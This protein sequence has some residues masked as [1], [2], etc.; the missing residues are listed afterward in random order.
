MGVSTGF[1]VYVYRTNQNRYGELEKAITAMQAQQVDQRIVTTIQSTPEAQAARDRII[2]SKGEIWRPVQEQIKD[3]VVQVFSQN[4]EIDIEQPFKTPNQYKTT[5][6]GFFINDQG[7]LLTNAHVVASAKAVWIQI[8]SFGK[9]IFDTTVVGFA[10]D[11]DIALL[12][13][14]PEGF[15]SIKAELKKVPHLTLGDSDRV[16]R[17]DEVMALGYPLGQESLKSTTGVISGRESNLIQMS[18]PIN[19]GS[20]GGPLLDLNGMVV[21]IN[22][23]GILEAQNI[24]YIIPINEVKVVLPNL[25]KEKILRKPF[26]GILYNNGTEALTEYLGNPKPGGCYIVEVVK[27]STL[28][29]AGVFRG[30]MIYE[31]NGHRIDMYGDMNVPW[32]EDKISITDYAARLSI[33]DT[34]KMVIYRNG[35]RKELTAPFSQMALPSIRKVYP[36]YEEIAYETVAGMVVME[37]TINHIAAMANKVPGLAQ[38]AELKNQAD[39][40]LIISHVFPTSYMARTR[41]ISKGTTINQVNGQSVHGLDEFRKALKKSLTTGF[42]T[43]QVSD[44][45]MRVSDHVFVVLPFDKVMREQPML[46][47]DYRYPVSAFNKELALAWNASAQSSTHQRSPGQDNTVT[48]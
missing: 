38:Y 37:L 40:V 6:S 48:A 43:L 16:C 31:I 5:G 27:N 30:D 17:S 19:P 42:L 45:V 4:V 35:K 39:P 11:H 33:G 28:Y 2:S 3:T 34:I 32:S 46:A 23:A 20:S 29:K 8:P 21:G 22:T 47:Y 7:Y 15:E 1:S 14:C 18:A 13:V 41:T 24:G 12:R 44:N 9:R 36:A 25:Y 26:L 10:P